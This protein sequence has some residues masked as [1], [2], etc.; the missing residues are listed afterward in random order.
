MK[1]IIVTKYKN[2]YKIIKIKIFILYIIKNII[3]L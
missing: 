3:N 2:K 1:I